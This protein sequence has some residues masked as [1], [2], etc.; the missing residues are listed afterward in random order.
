[1]ISFDSSD[2]D[3]MIIRKF[4]KETNFNRMIDT[5]QWDRSKV[6]FHVQNDTLQM[7]A[8]VG[9]ILLQSKYDYEVYVPAANRT[10]KVTEINE[11]QQEGNCKGK[12]MCANVIMS[13]KLDG[14]TRAVNYDI[15]YLKK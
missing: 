2:I 11:P 8:F 10:F 14:N 1:M 15:L 13:A 5:S 12:V 4:E 6:V 9:D 7:G 3:T